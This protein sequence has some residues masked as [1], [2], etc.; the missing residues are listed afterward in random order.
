MLGNLRTS[1]FFLS[2]SL[3]RRI[4]YLKKVSNT[5][6]VKPTA[7][8][9]HGVFF[10]PCSLALVQ[11][12]MLNPASAYMLIYTSTLILQHISGLSSYIYFLI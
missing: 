12:L 6:P 4:V 8:L 7:A 1:I 5:K 2:Y 9:C 3:A 11:K 10:F